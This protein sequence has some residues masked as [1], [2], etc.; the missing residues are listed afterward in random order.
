MAYCLHVQA[1]FCYLSTAKVNTD[2][3]DN[4]DVDD[5]LGCLSGWHLTVAITVKHVQPLVEV[6]GDT[7]GV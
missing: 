6:I 1:Y 5:G 7:G 3:E 4:V 2:D